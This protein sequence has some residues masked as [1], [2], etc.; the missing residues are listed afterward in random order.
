MHSRVEVTPEDY[1]IGAAKTEGDL[2][3]LGGLVETVERVEGSQV[4]IVCH[5]G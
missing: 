3:V 2:Y 4:R 1:A 5:K